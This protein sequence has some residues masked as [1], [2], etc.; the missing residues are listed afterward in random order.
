MTVCDYCRVR[1]GEPHTCPHRPDGC[2]CPCNDA[3][4]A[5][6]VVEENHVAGIDRRAGAYRG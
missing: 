4:Q 5:V 6:F 2:G 1:G 3:D